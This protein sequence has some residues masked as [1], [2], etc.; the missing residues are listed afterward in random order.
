L[1]VALGSGAFQFYFVQAD[2]LKLWED[3]KASSKEGLFRT[4]IDNFSNIPKMS[5]LDHDN[6]GVV[7]VAPSVVPNPYLPSFRIYSYNITGVKSAIQ[8]IGS[9]EYL[10][11][12][13]DRTPKHHRGENAGDKQKLCKEKEYKDTWKCRLQEPWNADEEAPS[14]SNT[15]WSPL[16]YTQVRWP[17]LLFH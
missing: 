7:N 15:L 3:P 8:D 9:A 11:T 10:R 2:D 17:Y 4:L 14:R 16:G 6:Y 13:K 5:K 1:V 12:T